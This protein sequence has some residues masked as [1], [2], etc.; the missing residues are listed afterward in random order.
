MKVRLLAVAAL[1]AGQL[2]AQN[3][4]PNTARVLLQ[5]G[6]YS[7]LESSAEQVRG[8][9]STSGRQVRVVA[10]NRPLTQLEWATWSAKGAINHGYLPLNAYLVEFQR[11]DSWLELANLPILG[12]S[13]F[14]PLM[15]LSSQLAEG[16]FPDYA[17]SGAD[18]EL[19]VVPLATASREAVVRDLNRIGRVVGSSALG[20]QVVIKPADL[21]RVT[22]LA[23]VQFVQP[24]EAPA[25]PENVIG[26]KNHRANAIRVPYL[27][28]RNYRGTGV[29]VGHGDD[30]DIQPHID[31]KGRIAA[32][33]GG[34]SQ[35]NHGDHVAGTIFGAGN[36]NPDG[37]GQA[38]GASLVYY[39]YPANLNSVDNHYA[40]YG[41][42][43]TASSYSNGCNAGYTAFTQQMDQDIIDNY[44]LMHVFSAGNSGT[45]NCNYGAGAGWGNITGG[46]KQG[47]NVIAVANLQGTDVIA[48]SSSRGPAHD[49]RI[50]PDVAA[51]GTNVF[52]CSSPNSYATLT[53]TSMACPG[54]AG[55]LAQLY[56]AYRQTHSGQDPHGGLMKAI[57]MN[58]ADDLGQPGPDFIHGYGRMNALRAAK[59]IEQNQFAK[60][61]LSPGETDTLRI[62]V[63]V[64]T[65]AVRIMLH[66]T[67]PAATV[68]A[69]RALVNNL[70]GV[71]KQGTSSWLPWVLNP[72]PTATA[73][74]SPAVRAV[75]SLNTAEQFEVLN[76]TPGDFDLIVSG[77]VAVGSAQE[78]FVTWSF[79]AAD[80][81]LT[82]PVGGEV[83]VAGQTTPVRWDSEPN[84]TAYQLSASYDNGAT[85]SVIANPGANADQANWSVPAGVNDQ[86]WLRIVRGT[87]GDTTD[88]VLSRIGVPTNLNHQWTCPDSFK[89]SWNPVVGAAGYVVYR[90]GAK[91]MDPVDT[92]TATNYV[93][94]GSNPN[95]AEWFSVAALTPAGRAGKRAVAV[96]KPAGIQ[97]CIV[98]QDAALSA[99]V[100]P[101][102]RMPDC[103]PLGSIPIEVRLLN[104]ATQA[105]TSVPV[106]VRLGT[107][108][109]QRD[110]VAVQLTSTQST[111]V[112]LAPT[113]SLPGIGNYSIRV[114]TELPGDQ[115]PYNDTLSTS[116]NVTASGTPVSL[117]YAENFSSFVSCPTTS[118]CGVTTCSLTNG[119]VNATNGSED[120]H[121]WR[122]DAG[123]TPTTGT[124][125]TGGA[126][127]GGPT[128]NYLYLEAT[129]CLNSTAMVFTPCINL[130][131]SSLPQ[132][133]FAAHMLGTNQGELHVDVLSGGRWHLDVCAPLVGDKGS[134]WVN[135]T[136]SLMPFTG[137]TIVVRFRGTTGNGGLSDIAIDAITVSEVTSAPQAAMQLPSA[138]PCLNQVVQLFDASTNSPASWRWIITPRTGV[139]FANGSDSTSKNPWVSFNA[140][141]TYSVQLIATNPFGSDTATSTT[142]ITLTAGAPLPFA[143]PFG[144]SLPL[145]WSVDNPDG[146][147]TWAISNCIGVAGTS[148]NAVTVNFFNYSSTLQEDGLVTPGIDLSGTNLPYLV[149]D[150]AYAPYDAS[151]IDG[152]RI[153]Y[154]TN[155]GSTW[156]PTGYAK[157]GSALAT[158]AAQTTNF[159]PSLA[160][161]WRRDSI[162][163]PASISGPSVKFRFVGVN[164]YGNNLFLDNIQVYDLGA[165]APVASISASATVDVCVLD[166]VYFSAVNPGNALAQWTFGPGAVPSVATGPGNHAVYFFSP[167]PKTITLQLNGAGGTDRDTV[168]LNA[169]P[170]LSST[171][172]IQTDSAFVLRGQAA[173]TQGSALGYLWDFGDG[174][175]ATT[176]AVRHVYAAAGT[177]PVQLTVDGPC[178]DV[179]FQTNAVISSIGLGE[180]NAKWA[181][182]P[183][184]TDGMLWVEGEGQPETFVLTDLAGRIVYQ[185]TWP[186]RGSLDV[187]S[188]SAG[189]YVLELNGHG[190]RERHLIVKR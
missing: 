30:G 18:V 147:I 28:G 103:Q 170:N 174:T 38:P 133:S 123:G 29:T 34:P 49:G 104:P 97:G 166:T 163:L 92:V 39:D 79:V 80:V 70:N 144:P 6:T 27:G 63:P 50:K 130:T 175:T 176:A 2:F 127:G 131:G 109:I 141:G 171:W 89:V 121:D 105:L 140:L 152:L 151:Y 156:A 125:P 160:S 66:W 161:H 20:I 45:S 58:T 75:D 24:K 142:G 76:P 56:D 187:A 183:N 136:A 178:N 5:S 95:V 113:L 169:V 3:T 180:G 102:G 100:N 78:Y 26:T 108:P 132:L 46:Q 154:S 11:E 138:A 143:E 61:S 15:K 60:D 122:T 73:L 69:G 85:W 116:V 168:S 10:F 41:V 55:V 148:T 9:G 145:G 135:V 87:Q 44:H 19:L 126:N 115:N 86:M 40:L 36:L 91:Y 120:Q 106:A 7:L 112:Q 43:V 179:V 114:W 12:A 25:E 157:S 57:L 47:K 59:S 101:S 134:S 42:R 54:T 65:Q 150:L 32:N 146:G 190:R 72:T 8:M 186:E 139:S 81:E 107:G 158:K 94:T 51:L 153:E 13:P 128:D 119:W 99:I 184:P 1:V 68:N 96:E 159:T 177:Y 173:V 64:G 52:S 185:G 117:P 155:C 181:A 110:T 71:L 129:N 182:T 17:W 93:F 62:T 84:G 67:D 88:V 118:N 74:N 14:T 77:S 172:S 164:G 137:K 98:T 83:L 189:S 165:A 16:S 149:F 188:L 22:K 167:G 48:G 90:L 162:A 4:I 31:F 82:Y 21:G 124:G 53:G 35:G 37:E 33:F 111:V 23:D